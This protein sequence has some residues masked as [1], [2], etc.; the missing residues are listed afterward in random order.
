MQCGWMKDV[1][2]TYYKSKPVQYIMRYS[3][4]QKEM[5]YTTVIATIHPER[6]KKD[7]VAIPHCLSVDCKW[8]RGMLAPKNA[9]QITYGAGGAKLDTG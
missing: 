1:Q 6:G 5:A 8:K 3:G 2:P 7:G 4:K 9:R